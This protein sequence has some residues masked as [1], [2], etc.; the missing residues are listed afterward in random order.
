[1]GPLVCITNKAEGVTLIG[2]G[3]DIFLLVYFKAF[4]SSLCVDAGILPPK[5]FVRCH[6]TRC[7]WPACKQG[8][9]GLSLALRCFES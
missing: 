5:L 2:L 9:G 7:D 1:M 8:S 4:I 6:L 3:A